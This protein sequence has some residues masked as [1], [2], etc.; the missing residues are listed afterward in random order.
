MTNLEEP[1]F[2]P[3]LAA[4]GVE[5]SVPS[6]SWLWREGDAGDHVALLLEGILEVVQDGAEGEIVVRTLESGAVVG[7]LA[8]SQGRSRSASVRAR[9]PCRILKVPSTSFR[10]L[11][12]AR[13][14]V[15]EQLYWMQVERV[16]NLTR[17]VVRS[18]RRV[19]NDP[20][21]GLLAAGF[22]QERLE[23]EAQRARRTGDFLSLVMLQADPWMG[24]R[25]VALALLARVARRRSRRADIVARWGRDTVAVLLYG[26]AGINAVRVAEGIREEIEATASSE[27]AAGLT[28]SAGAASLPADATDAEGLLKSAD[29]SLWAAREQGG[30]RVV[31][32]S[33]PVSTPGA[34]VPIAEDDA[35][36]L[37]RSFRAV[38]D[39]RRST[40]SRAF[41]D[42]ILRSMADTVIVTD[43]DGRIVLA[44]ESA[45]R[46][47]G[48]DGETELLGRHMASICPEG[49]EM[50]RSWGGGAVEGISFIRDVETA[51]RTRDGRTVPVSFAGSVMRDAHGSLQGVVCDAQDITDRLRSREE[52]RQAKDAAEQAS[53]AKST[54]LANMSHELRTPLNA[55]IG[56]SEMLIEE[57]SQ[58][59]EHVS[60][61]LHRVHGSARHLLGLINDVLDLSKI[62]AGRMDVH[63][64]DVALPPLLR[65]VL[66]SVRPVADKR[67][68][69]LELRCGEDCTTL[70]TDGMKL[71]QCLL[72]LLSNASKFTEDG[73][74]TLSVERE[75]RSG[76]RGLAFRVHDT[77]IGMTAAQMGRLFQAF[78]QA[79]ASTTR[80]YGGTGL[81][82][83]ITRRFAEM[84]GGTVDAQ[85][86]PGRGTTFTL[87]L[88]S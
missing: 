69:V 34:I 31:G 76:I 44:N 80:K 70:H 57:L 16:R 7:E 60:E 3:E 9:T 66:N 61:D 56:Y 59:P 67:G 20:S 51:Y 54:F 64:E 12:R 62:E 71:R 82:L 25:E 47:L 86:E 10:D 84:L 27:S 88:P 28:V 50:L 83:A 35:S 38:T 29:M 63:K 48:Y 18:Q 30:N 42:N 26:A 68:N 49:W 52:L 36:E 75:A 24:D 14:D 74:V 33:E 39:G 1:R 77:G 40:I 85:S 19:Y 65:E 43:G 45:A 21:T 4:L 8:A 13:P 17:R 2:D 41:L 79:D 55:I 46:L 72:N 73:V 6:G 81:G 53:Q 5:G 22:L 78:S 23:E 37:A 87:W 15:L 58:G 11:L 32:T